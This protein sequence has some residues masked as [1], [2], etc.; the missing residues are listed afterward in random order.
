MLKEYFSVFHAPTRR[1]T[2]F[3]TILYVCGGARGGGGG[4]GGGGGVTN[5]K[6]LTTAAILS[7]LMGSTDESAPPAS[8]N[9]AAINPKTVK[10][11][12]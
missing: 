11:M 5:E 10:S 8:D 3:K 6:W 9:I 1:K 2:A 12:I 4:G 7:I